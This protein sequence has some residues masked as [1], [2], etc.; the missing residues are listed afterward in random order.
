MDQ[1]QFPDERRA[2]DEAE[3]EPAREE[4]SP[5]REETGPAPEEAGPVPDGT[6]RAPEETVPAPD[7]T[8]ELSSGAAKARQVLQPE[9]RRTMR[10]SLFE[11]SAVQIFLNWTSG[12]VLIG[13]MLYL[14]ATPTQLGL[15]ASVPLLAQSMAPLAAWLAAVLGRRRLLV[16]LNALFARGLWILAAAVPALGLPPGAEPSFLVLLVLVSSVFQAANSTLW[17]SWMGDVIPDS[18][19]G[20]FFGTRTG[21][22]GVVGMLANLG[23]GWYLDRVVAPIGFQVVL[24]VGVVAALV[25]TALYLLHYDPPSVREEVSLL[26]VLRTPLADG[27]FRRF[28][29]FA[30]YWQFAVF[31]SA[32]FV[33]PYFLDHLQLTFTQIAIWSSIA[34]VSALVTTIAWGRV[35]DRFGNK[36]VLAIGTFLAGATL[37]ACWI[38]AGVTGEVAFIWVSAVFD[39]IA[40]GAIGPAIF[41]LALTT[42]PRGTR[43]SFFAMYALASGVA[44]FAGGAISGPL[45]ELLG[46]LASVSFMGVGLSP[47]YV[48]FVISGLARM[49]AWR[50]LR[51]VQ[52]TDAWRTR[53][54]L[55]QLRH[56]WRMAGFQWRA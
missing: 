4:T 52:E 36:T 16:V 55:R 29:V 44:G 38:L 5:T 15:V 39:A 41:N 8:G 22:V 28:L 11:G 3:A 13:Y 27:N 54:F 34:A 10:A 47:F 17:A 42:A 32:P 25:S 7:E 53:D 37:P 21:I 6:S 12:S 50:L 26:S 19:R 48:L 45:L 14:G 49:Q 2:G 24:A 1:S 43:T 30:V 40:W 46:P 20:R 23:A 33:F 31:L 56:G 18:L 9:V 51:R 35:A